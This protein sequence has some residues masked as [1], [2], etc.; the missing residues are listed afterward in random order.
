MDDRKPPYLPTK[1]EIEEECRKIR[2]DRGPQPRPHTP[3]K[4]G[5]AAKPHSPDSKIVEEAI[6]YVH[7]KG[8]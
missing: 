3:N 6:N 7:K 2:E 5:R 8:N 1:E 4:K